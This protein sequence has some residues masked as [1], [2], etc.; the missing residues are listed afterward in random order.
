R[1][2]RAVR[3]AG[4]CSVFDSCNSRPRVCEPW[5]AG[6]A[7][8]EATWTTGL[9]LPRFVRRAALAATVLFLVASAPAAAHVDPYGNSLGFSS[10]CN[11]TL[12]GVRVADL[13]GGRGSPPIFE[14]G[15]AWV[16]YFGIPIAVSPPFTVSDGLTHE[17]VWQVPSP[18]SL[19]PGRYTLHAL[20]P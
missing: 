10:P 5:A 3:A 20:L 4:A 16:D 11:P 15:V 6:V 14:N 13:G 9:V 7:C 8:G 18:S 17:L 2:A 19:P 12:A 1:L